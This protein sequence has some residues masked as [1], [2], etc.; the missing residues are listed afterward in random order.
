MQKIKY[1]KKINIEFKKRK[2]C[3]RGNWKLVDNLSDKQILYET[4]DLVSRLGLNF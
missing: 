2:K 4:E 1:L 3:S